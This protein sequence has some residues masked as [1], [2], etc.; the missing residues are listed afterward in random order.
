MLNKIIPF[1]FLSLC[2]CAQP[3]RPNVVPQIVKVEVPVPCVVPAVEEPVFITDAELATMSDY[4]VIISL[5]V[6]HKE[7]KNYIEE[8]KASNKGCS[9]LK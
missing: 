7:R 8:L 2:S 3:V 9:G 1:L 6:D 4:Q 5:W